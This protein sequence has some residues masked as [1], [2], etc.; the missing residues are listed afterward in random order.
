MAVWQVSLPL[1]PCD[2]EGLR[3]G[4]QGAVKGSVHKAQHACIS[5]A[6][7][8]AARALERRRAGGAGPEEGARA[9]APVRLPLT[10][11]DWGALWGSC[12]ENLCISP[13]AR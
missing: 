10:V 11:H 9:G 1:W 2:L 13:S 3:A 6:G 5:G 12:A 4:Y 8:T 7:A